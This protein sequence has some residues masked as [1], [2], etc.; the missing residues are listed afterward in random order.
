MSQ[1]SIV[2]RR[3]VVEPF[4]VKG[5][6]VQIQHRL[7]HEGVVVQV[8]GRMRLALA[9]GPLEPPVARHLRQH[10]VRRPCRRVAVTRIAEDSI[11]LGH[12]R[13]HQTIPPR[14]NLVVEVRLDALLA[15]VEK[16]LS[17][18]GQPGFEFFRRHLVQFRDGLGG[19]L[20]IQNVVVFPVTILRYVVVIAKERGVLA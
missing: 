19:P 18:S 12:A 1:D 17:R 6:L 7:N 2:E 15:G 4:D 3:G 9:I 8:S 11:A 14:E 16:L 5:R 20:H 13:D 10:E